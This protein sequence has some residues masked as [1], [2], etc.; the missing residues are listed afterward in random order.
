MFFD[1]TFVLLIPAILL[2]L[3]A[4]IRVRSAFGTYSRVRDLSGLT[5]AQAARMLLDANGLRDVG[6][7]QIRGNLTD[8]YDPRVRTLYLSQS[9]YD[10]PS[11]A[12]V[13]VA[14]HECGHAMQH[15]EGYAPLRIRSRIVPV[16]N[17][18]SN[19]SW[20]LIMVGI[21]L[22]A[23]DPNGGGYG[24]LLFD[25][26]VIAF[27]CVIVFHLVTLPVELNASERA[28]EQMET[29]QIVTAGE[30]LEGSRKVLRAAALTYVAALIMS[31][32]NL[33]RLL[34]IRRRG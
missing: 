8:N 7:Q 28:L 18:A 34:V 33:L 20:V 27:V 31:V 21:M 13:S 11:V 10:V 9:V 14:C 1:Y 24:S 2:S 3:Y 6:I 22:M 5:G 25:I 16:V 19:L 15:A 17:I 30:E 4:N 29:M 32:A 26:G 12:A 23:Y